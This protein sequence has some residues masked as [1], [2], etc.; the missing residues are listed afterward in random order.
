MTW[1]KRQVNFLPASPL[2]RQT[3]GLLS[4]INLL[5][6]HY[7]KEIYASSAKTPARY[8]DFQPEQRQNIP[9]SP[10]DILPVMT[11]VRCAEFGVLHSTIIRL[12]IKAHM[13]E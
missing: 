4:R 13:K 8:I 11:K 12:I 1:M 7:R 5:S 3:N 2:V 6:G 10:E 9:S